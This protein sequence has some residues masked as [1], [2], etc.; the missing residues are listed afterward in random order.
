MG[1]LVRSALGCY[2]AAKAFGT[3]FI[4]GKDSLNNEYRVGDQTI[5]IPG[6]LLISGIGVMADA[7][8]AISM[9]AKRAGNK[10]Y[11]V[12]ATKKEM[13]GSAY[14][15]LLGVTGGQVPQVDLKGAPSA[16]RRL[17]EAIA[18][19]LVISAHDCSEGGL[20][21]AAAEMAFAGGLGLTLDLKKVPADLARE[22]FILFSESAS[23][24]LLEV[25]PEK[26]QEFEKSLGG[27]PFACVG[28]FQQGS[29][30]RVLGL[31]GKPVVETSVDRLR[32]AWEAPFRGW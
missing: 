22:D 19:G 1:S 29:T 28:E 3:P 2:D 11:L 17:S 26:G 18:A 15:A 10:L 21:V 16:M 14:H 32:Q 25:P 13:G 5:Q 23:R 31:D 6:T 12:G 24:I 4:S 27:V 20:A 7:A 30:F 9:D 8:R